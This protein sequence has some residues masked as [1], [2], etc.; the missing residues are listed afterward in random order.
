MR[1]HP[2]EIGG[3]QGR[4]VEVRGDQGR[5]SV[6]VRGAR[7]A[8]ARISRIISPLVCHTIGHVGRLRSHRLWL[9]YLHHRWA[10]SIAMVR[11]GRSRRSRIQEIKNPEDLVDT[12]IRG[13]TWI[14]G[15]PRDLGIRRSTEGHPR[16]RRK[17]SRRLA[18]AS[19]EP[20]ARACVNVCAPW[21]RAS[22]ERR[23]ARART[24][25][26]VSSRCRAVV[27]TYTHTHVPSH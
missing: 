1:E 7:H 15:D 22:A 26:S 2:G 21:E 19:E 3:A 25:R 20:E 18:T 11:S 17:M 27:R 23:A 24:F 14:L 12:R 5:S 10:T 13:D 9:R 16:V 8:P 6:E 4:S